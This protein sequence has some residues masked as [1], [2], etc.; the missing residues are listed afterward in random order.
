MSNQI[1]GDPVDVWTANIPVK[2][3]SGSS[4]LA[5]SINRGQ[6]ADGFAENPNDNK[7]GTISIV[8]PEWNHSL[9][10]DGIIVKRKREVDNLPLVYK[11]TR[12][13]KVHTP[14][15][16]ISGSIRLQG[17]LDGIAT[18]L[19]NC[20]SVTGIPLKNGN[21]EG[22]YP[23][24]KEHDIIVSSGSVGASSGSYMIEAPSIGGGGGASLMMASA[25]DTL[26]TDMVQTS[27]SSRLA[28]PEHDVME[29]TNNIV[30][31]IQDIYEKYP[32]IKNLDYK[33]KYEDL[34]DDL[35]QKYPK[36]E[37]DSYDDSQKEKVYEEFHNEGVEVTKN[38]MY[39]DVEGTN[40]TRYDYTTNLM[41][42]I[43]N[44][45]AEEVN[46]D[47]QAMD[48]DS[49]VQEVD[50]NSNLMARSFSAS[51]GNVEGALSSMVG[52]MSDPASYNRIGGTII[53]C[54]SL[55]L[56]S[57]GAAARSAGIS[58][59]GAYNWT[60]ADVVLNIFGSSTKLGAR[61]FN[62]IQYI[63][64]D[65]TGFITGVVIGGATISIPTYFISKPSSPWFEY[66]ST[67]YNKI[68]PSGISTLFMAVLELL[69]AV[70]AIAGAVWGPLKIGS[71]IAQGVVDTIPPEMKSYVMF[72]MWMG[73]FGT[74]LP[75]F[76]D[77]KM[78]G[79]SWSGGTATLDSAYN[80][81]TYNGIS[82]EVMKLQNG[83]TP[84]SA[85]R[86]NV[87]SM[88]RTSQGGNIVQAVG[89]DVNIDPR[90][91]YFAIEDFVNT[92]ESGVRVV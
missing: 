12:V 38:F 25:M 58:A 43:D 32:M 55:D 26:S 73:L 52:A 49:N 17:S 53:G 33:F 92:I 7:V 68:H 2:G 16:P 5:N 37:F 85:S 72:S 22:Y 29:T 76:Q 19:Y 62:G 79:W 90:I 42:E 57:V 21:G 51:G 8:I 4:V 50:L 47:I 77:L 10:G 64:E 35:K 20:N 56:E 74:D 24:D 9:D 41:K 81:I 14:G 40:V 44:R 66:Y 30:S 45:S 23:V 86:V 36:E 82:D 3:G 54:T 83:V 89:I 27:L 60:S 46:Q 6:H 67:N 39:S 48:F 11:I 75:Y 69:P 91:P 13:T 61:D 18:V 34:T 80:I 15:N 70:L 88:L 65:L 84:S 59:H 78:A 63:T 28:M 87:L 71:L 1:I 31:S